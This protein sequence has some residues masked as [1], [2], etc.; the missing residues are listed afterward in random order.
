MCHYQTD[1]RF[2][3]DQIKVYQ[4]LAMYHQWYTKD[5]QLETMYDLKLF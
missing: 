5:H 4:K 3:I 2:D 1:V